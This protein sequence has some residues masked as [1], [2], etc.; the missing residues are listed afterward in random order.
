MEELIEIQPLYLQ[1]RK[2][3]SSLPY[4]HW[5]GA[6]QPRTVAHASEQDFPSCRGRGAANPTS[7]CL[8]LLGKVELKNLGSLESLA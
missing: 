8:L 6:S 2:A 1:P 3:E 4:S 7:P 5:L